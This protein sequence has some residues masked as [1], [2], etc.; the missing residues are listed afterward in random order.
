[1]GSFGS[2][3]LGIASGKCHT[4][5]H[6]TRHRGRARSQKHSWNYIRIMCVLL[7]APH[8]QVMLL[9]V[10]KQSKS[11]TQHPLTPR[12]SDPGYWASV[13]ASAA[14]VPHSVYSGIWDRDPFW[15]LLPRLP[16]RHA[17]GCPSTSQGTE[18]ELGKH[19]PINRT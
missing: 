12:M 6:A 2:P 14:K 1:M 16:S 4:G 15:P 10:N 11:E 5:P 8:F 7:D 3:G 19:T 18:K 17:L 9:C 13:P